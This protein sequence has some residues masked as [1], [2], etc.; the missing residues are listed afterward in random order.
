[1]YACTYVFQWIIERETIKTVDWANVRLQGYRTKS[2]TP[3]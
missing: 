3:N 1:M 2:V